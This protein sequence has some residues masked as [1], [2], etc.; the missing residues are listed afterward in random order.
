MK[1]NLKIVDFLDKISPR[2]SMW[3]INKCSTMTFE[4]YL[5]AVGIRS[6]EF[7]FKNDELFQNTKYFKKCWK[8]NLSPYKALL[9]LNDEIN[10]K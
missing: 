2:L 5:I 8:S 6:K 10:N 3:Y 4:Q 1:L 7:S 9:F